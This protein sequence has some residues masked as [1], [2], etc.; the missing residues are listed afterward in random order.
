MILGA[1]FPSRKN[2][3]QYSEVSNMNKSLSKHNNLIFSL[4]T[5]GSVERKKEGVKGESTLYEPNWQI[6]VSAHTSLT[7]DYQNSVHVACL[8]LNYMCRIVRSTLLCISKLRQRNQFHLSRVSTTSHWNYSTR[9][10]Y[11]THFWQ[12]IRGAYAS[13]GIRIRGHTHQRSTPSQIHILYYTSYIFSVLL[14]EPL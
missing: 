12:R 14:P 9:Y 4:I 1:V 7:V 2:T 6:T 3:H 5:E 13:E 10:K 8:L 11:C